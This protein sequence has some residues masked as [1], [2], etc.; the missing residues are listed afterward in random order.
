MKTKSFIIVLSFLLP[1]L[2]AFKPLDDQ[3]VLIYKGKTQDFAAL[4]KLDVTPYFR[5]DGWLFTGVSPQAVNLV[6]QRGFRIDVVDDNPWSEPYYL[7]T[8]PAVEFPVDLPASFREIAE[9]PEG[10]IVK[11]PVEGTK[12]L[13]EQGVRGVR[14]QDKRIPLTSG[15]IGRFAGIKHQGIGGRVQSVVDQVSDSTI[16]EYIT[17]LVDF[18]TRF[19]CTDSVEAAGEWIHDIFG[20]FGFTDVTF[21]SF[22]INS[23]VPCN[24]QRN[25]VAVKQGTL[26][27]D[28]VIVIGGHYD[29]YASTYPGCDP[30]T[31]APG[32]D[33]DASGTVAALEAARV[34]FE[35]DTEKTLIFVAFGGEEQW[36]WGSYDFAEEAYNQGMDIIL[37][38]NLDMVANLNDDYWDIQLWEDADS[39]PFARVMAEMAYDYTGLIP[40]V[41]EG[42]Y[43]GD[44]IPFWEYGYSSVYAAESDHSPHYHRCTDT[45]EN[46]S[47]PY[48]TDVTRMTVASILYVSETPNSPSGFSAVNVGDGTSLYLVWD[49]NSEL[50]IEGYNIYYGTQ[51]GNY[52]S[53]KTVTSE[54]DTL[55]DLLEGT[56]YY[57][58]LSAVDA[59]SNESFL[60]EEIEITTGSMP[61][62]PTGITSTSNDSTI[63]IDWTGN[64]ELDLVG[65]NLYR[66]EIGGV[67]DTVWQA[68]VPAPT[69]IFTDDTAETHVLYG[70]YVTALDNQ[71]P[72][73]ES[74]PSEAVY[75]R[76]TTLDMGILV[77]DNTLD[78]TGSPLSPTDEAVDLFYSHVLRNYNMSAMWDVGDSSA[79]GRY[80]MDYDTGIYSVV[81]WHSDVRQGQLAE[82][83]TTTIRKYLAVGGNLWLTGWQVLALLEGG[84]DPYYTFEEG[85][86][87]AHYVGIDSA[88]TTS[89][90]DQD[91][92]GVES[93]VGGFQTIFI[94]SAKV[95]PIGA[96]YNMEVLLPPFVGASPLYSYISSDS[97]SS[98][99]H[100]IPVAVKSNSTD[101]GLVLTDFPLYFMD[102]GE[103]EYLA[104]AVMELFGEPVSVGGNGESVYLPHVYSLSQNYPNP[105]NPSTTIR[106]DIPDGNG[107]VLVKVHIYDVRGRLVRRLVDRQMDPGR[108]QVH[109]DGRNDQRRSVSSGVYLYRIEAGDFTSTRKM[110]MIR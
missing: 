5:G 100:G 49:P 27:P 62:T 2:I 110:L 85:D 37:M 73:N 74:D 94:D 90:G 98:D 77:V 8:K 14:I 86:F 4:E 93:L 36:M 29:S 63:T 104:D 51:S 59:D 45:I 89:T 12:R 108:Y 11:G 46:I 91:F 87:I 96:L 18:R 72:Q 70:Y 102:Q 31:L 97:T 44:A 105:F 16:T 53:V 82:T 10:L 9:V 81:L 28:R 22:P 64:E 66:W 56:A 83:D 34:L 1:F 39:T 69:S 84:S 52:D 58:A 35:V 92:I 107:P 99:H 33:D 32:A 80:L 88:L 55:Q 71:V 19:S 43:P 30:D 60:T 68:F 6:E 78:G 103:S 15:A 24:I 47:I 106:Y 20:E 42:T 79:V 40:D 109:W 13:V 7:L 75:G 21:D 57:L 76:L 38:I 50:D 17:R 65:Y 101:Y 67:P 61:V 3:I 23:W 54:E 95:F 26:D 48:L 25:V 41:N